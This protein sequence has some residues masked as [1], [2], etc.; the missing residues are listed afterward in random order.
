M[1]R[2]KLDRES[3]V[4][5]HAT[6]ATSGAERL[7]GVFATPSGSKP[8][9]VCDR[10]PRIDEPNSP[11]RSRAPGAAERSGRGR[12]AKRDAAAWNSVGVLMED[13]EER[14]SFASPETDGRG[15]IKIRN[16]SAGNAI[17]NPGRPSATIEEAYRVTGNGSLS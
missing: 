9:T 1:F 7:H 12:R 16:E 2:A 3:P 6:H 8:S 15:P 11:A 4:T 13:D 10:T 14:K 5:F 17:P